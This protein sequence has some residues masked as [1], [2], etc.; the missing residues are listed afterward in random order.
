MRIIYPIRGRPLLMASRLLTHHRCHLENRQVHGNDHPPTTPPKIPSWTVPVVPS[1]HPPRYPLRHHKSRQSLD[2]MASR[3]PVASPTAIIWTTIGGNMPVS[4]RGSAMVFPSLMLFLTRIRAFSTILLPAVLLTMARPS[5]IGTPLVH[6]RGHGSCKS[7]YGN[8]FSVM[9]QK[10]V[11]SE[12]DHQSAGYPS[13]FCNT[14]WKHR[15]QS[16]EQ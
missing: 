9:G 16:P 1:S 8:F 14:V 3:A 10:Q 15:Q 6:H 7:R 5:R 4:S 13:L 11:I 12:W 2:S